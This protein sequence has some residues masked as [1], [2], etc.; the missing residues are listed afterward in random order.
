[1]S[2]ADQVSISFPQLAGGQWMPICEQRAG[3]K[4]LMV[5]L[6]DGWMIL[7]PTMAAPLVQWPT[8]G[9]APAGYFVG[10]DVGN[11]PGIFRLSRE[12]DGPLIDYEWFAWI[13]AVV[14]QEIQ[15]VFT[16]SG[17]YTVPVGATNI[18]AQGWGTGGGSWSA[19]AGS[20]QST[21]GGGGGAFAQFNGPT[22]GPGLYTYFLGSGGP[23]DSSSP[24]EDVWISTTGVAP[25]SASEGFLAVGGSPSLG[26]AAVAGGVGGQA[27]ACI[28][29]ANG[30]GGK[31]GTGAVGGGH[32]AGA[33]G[34]GGGGNAGNPFG[35]GVGGAGVAGPGPVSGGVGGLLGG[36][37]VVTGGAGGD[38]IAASSPDAN[39]GL[40]WG[41]LSVPG[42]GGAGGAGYRDDG[43]AG[44]GAAGG[45]GMIALTYDTAAYVIVAVI[46]TMPGPP[47]P[48]PATFSATLGGLDAPGLAA[49]QSL[50]AKVAAQSGGTTGAIPD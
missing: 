17:T 15:V 16:E 50:L 8:Y 43:T 32:G 22:F 26:P 21:A 30:N 31:G 24:G 2:D 36:T 28:G 12:L 33:S 27:A 34:G 42:G 10:S 1:M 23:P 47:P 44:A 9:V 6:V 41:S 19:A 11:G 13:P 25:T 37:A 46:E 48:P 49:L 20:G 18:R 35:G 4:S 39:P 29:V 7:S 45:T 40:S 38:D 3:R 5:C 14:S